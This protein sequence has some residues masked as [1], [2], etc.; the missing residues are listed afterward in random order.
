MPN[1]GSRD[2]SGNLAPLQSLSRLC[3]FSLGHWVLNS[4]GTCQLA[5]LQDLEQN[6]PPL[7]QYSQVHTDRV[8]FSAY[9]KE[10]MCLVSVSIF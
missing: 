6:S 2:L 8:E 5:I 7:E 10:Y 3:A 9:Y 1:V 4:S